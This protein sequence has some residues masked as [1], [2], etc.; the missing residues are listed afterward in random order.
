MCNYPM[1]RAETYESYINQKGGKSYKTEW[2]QRD[3]VDNAGGIEN[4]RKIFSGK[5]RKIEFTQCGQCIPCLLGY[6]RD[7]ATQ[8]MLEKNFG[9]EDCQPYPDGTTWMITTTYKDEYLKT[10]KTCNTDTGEIFE[11]ISLSIKDD[12]DFMKRLRYYYPNIKIKRVVAGEYGSKTLRPHYHSIIFGLPLDTSKFK[13]WNVNEFGQKTWMMDD[14]NDIWGMGMVNI[15]RVEWQNAAYVARY[16]LKKAFKKDKQWYQM[17]GMAPEFIHWSNGI[18]KNYFMKNYEDI[19]KTDSVPIVNSH[20]QIVK[21]P[22]SYDRM[23]KEVDQELYN[24]IKLYRDKYSISN[25]KIINH[26]TDLT[27]EERRKVSEARMQ[28]VMK[29]I[30]LEV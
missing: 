12:Q 8:I 27:P 3:Q 7:K 13:T 1:V 20:G 2:L 21:P 10:N 6:S 24:K 25:E 19:Y 17:Q 14:L 4:L 26:Q 15:A 29:D 22:R 16:A 11:G 23:L 5:Y 28:Q 9:Y 18:G 30:R